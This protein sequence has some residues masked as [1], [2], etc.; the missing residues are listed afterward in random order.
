MVPLADY[1]TRPSCREPIRGVRIY[2]V[3][4]Q[5]REILRRKRVWIARNILR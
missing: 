1:L 4:L 5:G 2:D 3:E